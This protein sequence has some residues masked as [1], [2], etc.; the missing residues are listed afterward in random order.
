MQIQ[1]L[2]S[3]L[4]LATVL[5]SGLNVVKGQPP[6]P[7]KLLVDGC[8]FYVGGRKPWSPLRQMM[9]LSIHLTTINPPVWYLNVLHTWTFDLGNIK[10]MALGMQIGHQQDWIWDL[11]N[12]ILTNPPIKRLHLHMHGTPVVKQL[13]PT[14]SPQK[15][16][17]QQ[18]TKGPNSERQNWFW[19]IYHLGNKVCRFWRPRNAEHSNIPEY[20]FGIMKHIELWIDYESCRPVMIQQKTW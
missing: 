9:K 13:L 19:C 8:L 7:N 1:I 20:P 2:L 14:P 6:N 18:T 15:K 3:W 17:E 12:L 5:L 11:N 10:W 16:E 4:P